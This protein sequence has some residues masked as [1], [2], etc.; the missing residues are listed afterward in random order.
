M[1]RQ[2][3]NKA[4]HTGQ[5]VNFLGVT[6]K[7]LLALV[8]KLPRSKYSEQDFQI[9]NKYQPVEFTKPSSSNQSEVIHFLFEL[10]INP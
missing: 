10:I 2:S 9:L 1:I 4:T 3:Q 7:K 6:G 5:I 8:N